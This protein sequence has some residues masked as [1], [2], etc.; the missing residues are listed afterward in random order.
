MI[1]YTFIFYYKAIQYFTWW[2]RHLITRIEFT[3]ELRESANLIAYDVL[4]LFLAQRI[5]WWFCRK[6]KLAKNAEIWI[7]ITGNK[8]WRFVVTL[9]DLQC[10]VNFSRFRLL[11]RVRGRGLEDKHVAQRLVQLLFQRHDSGLVVPREVLDIRRNFGGNLRKIQTI[12]KEE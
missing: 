4:S 7:I 2:N 12:R 1:I 11:A 9:L 8:T 5:W 6:L 3:L 10:H